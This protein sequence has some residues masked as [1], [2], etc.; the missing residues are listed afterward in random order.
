MITREAL[1]VLHNNL[2]FVK[3]VNRQYSDEFAKS[4]AKIGSTVNI[5]KPNRYFVRNSPVMAVQNTDETS[6]PLT[7]SNQWGVDVNFTS[8][9]L[10]LSLDDFSK[11]ILTPAMARLASRIDYDGLGQFINIYN[12]VGTP[13]VTPGIAGGVVGNPT[14]SIAPAVYLNAGVW[15]DGQATP[16]DENRRV[17]ISPSAMSASVGA[18]AGLWQDQGLIAEQYRKGVI[19]TALGFEFAMDQNINLLTTGTRAVPTAATVTVAG[20]TGSNLLTQGWVAG[21]TLNQ[22]EIFSIAGVNA[23]NPENQQPI[24]V[25]V[26]AGTG[27]QYFVVTANCVADGAGLMTIPIYPPI[28]VAAPLV[29]AGT[30]TASPAAGALLTLLSGALSTRF[31]INLAYHQDAFT[32]G[33]ADLEMPNGVDFA[34]RETYDGISMRIVRAYDILN[35]QFPCRVDVLGGWATLRPELA[36]RIA[37]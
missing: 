15:M 11:R 24:D 31:P 19:G 23:V 21:V 27:N 12:Q 7:L 30:V 37:G 9:Q 28:V 1:R 25:V 20:Q 32:L 10:T 35:D 29:A 13:G 16:R 22:G 4:G 8:A 6:V 26:A 3:G 5:R 36:S 18:L 33:T 17:V 34:A 2:V 14:N